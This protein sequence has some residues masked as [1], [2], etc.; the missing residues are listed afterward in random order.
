MIAESTIYTWRSSGDRRCLE[1]CV[2]EGRLES[3][4]MWTSLEPE[5]READHAT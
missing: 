2:V 5:W 4:R 3:W 1:V